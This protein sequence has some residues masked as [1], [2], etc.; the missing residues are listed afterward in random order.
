M[1]VEVVNKTT[2]DHKCCI[3]L[4]IC[5]SYFGHT[6]QKGKRKQKN[7]FLLFP[8]LVRFVLEYFIYI[9][10]QHA[11]VTIILDNVVLIKNYIYSRVENQVESVFNAN[12]IQLVGIVVIAKKHFIV[13]QIYQSHIHIFVKVINEK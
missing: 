11:I 5:T 8:I 13:I 6:P 2:I 4:L 1:L 7:I 9:F 3:S 10:L 12:I